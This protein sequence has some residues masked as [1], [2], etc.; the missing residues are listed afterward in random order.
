MKWVTYLFFLQRL[1]RPGGCKVSLVGGCHRLSD[2]HSLHPRRCAA[3]GTW[4]TGWSQVQTFKS[5]SL[6]ETLCSRYT[7]IGS[8]SLLLESQEYLCADYFFNHTVYLSTLVFPPF[9][10]LLY[11]PRIMQHSISPNPCLVFQEPCNPFS[12]STPALSSRTYATLS[13]PP[14]PAFSFKNHTNNSLLQPLP[15]LLRTTQP[16]SLPPT[17]ALSKP[18][19]CQTWPKYFSFWVLHF[20]VRSCCCPT[21]LYQIIT[22][23]TKQLK[24]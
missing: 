19:W 1:P 24:P 17:P 9:Q 21:L 10:P 5:L 2:T 12:P 18:L 20:K 4:H 3:P 23:C 13:L 8:Q 22:F 16:T 7:H 6:R 11:H 14:T 15:F